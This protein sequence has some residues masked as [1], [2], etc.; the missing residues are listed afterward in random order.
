M[1]DADVLTEGTLI[2]EKYRVLNFI[3]GGAMARVY[4]VKNLE[5]NALLALKVHRI[6]DTPEMT[7]ASAQKTAEN[8]AAFLQKLSHPALPYIVETF[9]ENNKFYLVMEFI[10]G[11]TLKRLMDENANEPLD[12]LTVVKWGLQLCDVLNYLHIQHPPIIFRDVKPANIICRPNGMICLIDFGIARNA[13]KRKGNSTDT[14]VFGSP[15][16]APPEQYGH[17]QT[18]PRSDIYALGATLHHLL[19]GNDPSLTPFKWASLRTENHAVPRV[20]EKLVMRCVEFDAAR[21]PETADAVMRSLKSIQSMMEDQDVAALNPGT[22]DLSRSPA[23]AHLDGRTQTGELAPLSSV[24]ATFAP[25][26][27]ALMIEVPAPS[28][29]SSDVPDALPAYL[30]GS[31]MDWGF[32]GLVTGSLL[33]VLACIGYLFWSSGSPG[34]LEVKLPRLVLALLAI[35]ALLIGIVVPRRVTRNGMM[36]TIVGILLLIALSGLIFLPAQLSAF[37]GCVGFALLLLIA[38]TLLLGTE[39]S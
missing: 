2:H 6:V 19:T 29:S 21:R 27:P 28:A 9:S 14:I 25:I 8:E 18:T 16:Y 23:L 1:L 32:K 26:P 11:K 4:R 34:A 37:L 39:I 15:G 20:L 5:T 12:V 24:P 36:V 22:G 3:G 17:G 31:A 13:N 7:A 30:P 38:A 33:A 10:E 35:S